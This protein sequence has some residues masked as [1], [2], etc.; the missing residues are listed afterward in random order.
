MAFLRSTYAAAADLA[1]WDRDALEG[2]LQ[3]PRVP[4]PVGG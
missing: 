3:E 2:D 4:R 1:D